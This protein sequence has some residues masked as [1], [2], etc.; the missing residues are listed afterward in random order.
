M[1]RASESLGDAIAERVLTPEPLPLSSRRSRTT[2]SS[3]MATTSSSSSTS[4]Y[5]RPY[6][7]PRAEERSLRR[8]ITW[9]AD[10]SRSHRQKE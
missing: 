4:R 2:A 3:E 8:W 5:R 10:A 1:V 9:M 7:A 6:S